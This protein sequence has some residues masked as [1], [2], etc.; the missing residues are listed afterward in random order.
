MKT[1][2]RRLLVGKIPG[3]TSDKIE[4]TGRQTK[5]AVAKLNEEEASR[6]NIIARSSPFSNW[7]KQRSN[8]PL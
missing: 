4:R 1:N 8:D 3:R 2:K 7:H 6:L 5:K